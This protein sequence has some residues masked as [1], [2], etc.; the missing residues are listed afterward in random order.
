MTVLAARKEGPQTFR[1][2]MVAT[3]SRDGRE[4]AIA[5]DEVRKEPGV[6]RLED[7]RYALAESGQ[8]SP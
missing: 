6:R 8:P 3:G 1:D 5:L 4:I 7:G 2:L